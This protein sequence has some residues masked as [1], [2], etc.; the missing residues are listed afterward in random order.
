MAPGGTGAG[1]TRSLLS[2]E[3]RQYGASLGEPRARI[4]LQHP[5]CGFGPGGG[6]GLA[7]RLSQTSRARR[8][9]VLEQRSLIARQRPEPLD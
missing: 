2:L 5:H 3:R 7:D 4:D 6:A 8:G 9:W 1:V